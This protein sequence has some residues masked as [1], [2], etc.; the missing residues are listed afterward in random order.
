MT[1][2]QRNHKIPEL[3]R[4]IRKPCWGIILMIPKVMVRRAQ[5]VLGLPEMEATWFVARRYTDIDLPDWPSDDGGLY[6]SRQL[7]FASQTVLLSV[8]SD[9]GRNGFYEIAPGCEYPQRK[10]R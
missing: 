9:I 7:D 4:M 6:V 10:V 5:A 1:E 8:T 3:D 2:E